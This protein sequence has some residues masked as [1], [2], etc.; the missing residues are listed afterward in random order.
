MLPQITPPKKG[1]CAYVNREKDLYSKHGKMLT[2]GGSKRRVYKC[3]LHYFLQLFCKF[4][5]LKYTKFQ[6]KKYLLSLSVLSF[7]R[8]IHRLVT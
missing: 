3:S 2:T 5:I 6:R 7:M 8:G 1:V 4:E